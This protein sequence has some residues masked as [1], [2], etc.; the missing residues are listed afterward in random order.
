MGSLNVTSIAATEAKVLNITSEMD[1]RSN[2]SSWEQEQYADYMRIV[3][4]KDVQEITAI[5][6]DPGVK[7]LATLDNVYMQGAGPFT[8][9]PPTGWSQFALIREAQDAIEIDG[10]KFVRLTQE[11][12]TRNVVG[13][14]DDDKYDPNWS[15]FEWTF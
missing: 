14:G 9:T 1:I 5:G 11:W 7:R 2:P 15:T 13:G 3:L 6:F 12:V 10:A 4:Q 8:L